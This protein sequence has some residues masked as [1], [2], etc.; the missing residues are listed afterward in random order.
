[1]IFH[2]DEE[3]FDGV[4]ALYASTSEH[5]GYLPH[6]TPASAMGFHVSLRVVA[7]KTAD[8]KITVL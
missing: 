3:S 1:M 6:T 2:K 5:V 7:D 8:M 4:Q